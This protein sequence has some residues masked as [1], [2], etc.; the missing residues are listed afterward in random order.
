MYT[1]GL[2]NGRGAISVTNS[3]MPRLI[4]TETTSAMIPTRKV[5]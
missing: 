5:P 2:R 1:I 3:A 4:G